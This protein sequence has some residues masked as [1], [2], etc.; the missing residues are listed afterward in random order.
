MRF[1]LL[2]A[3]CLCFYFSLSKSCLALPVHYSASGTIIDNNQ[4]L[5]TI[6]GWVDFDDQLRSWD[7]GGAGQ[8]VASLDSIG[9]NQFY[10]TGYSIKV[11]EH[12]FSGSSGHLYME[13]MLDQSSNEWIFGDTM[14]F[15]EDGT[16]PWDEWIGE[17]FNFF[18]PDN[19]AQLFPSQYFD[20]AN[21]IQLVAFDY[22]FNDSILPSY[23]PD[24]NLWLTKQ[25]PAHTPE[26]ST[27][28]LVGASL[29]GLFAFRRFSRRY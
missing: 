17:L 3:V 13:F 6:S 18:N 9:Q 25:D 29:L 8:P 27:F 1:L 28:V 21:K 2:S 15:L 23:S 20:L 10:I 11:G 12:V 22:N 14:W 7:G 4:Q 26:P 5:L 24:F 16:G 19:T